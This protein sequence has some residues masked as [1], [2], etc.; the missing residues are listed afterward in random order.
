MSLVV[1]IEQ[2][3]LENESDLNLLETESDLN[4][5]LTHTSPAG[6]LALNKLLIKVWPLCSLLG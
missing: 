2:N 3:L 1:Y 5:S 6:F 4:L